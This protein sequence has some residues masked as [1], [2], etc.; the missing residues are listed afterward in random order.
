MPKT[1][2]TSFKNKTLKEVLPYILMI[3]GILG[4]LASFVITIEKLHL[5][6]NPNYQPTCSINPV[7]SCGPIMASPEASAF[8]FPNPLIGIFGFALVINVGV[9]MLAGAKLKGWYWKLFNLGT[10]F[11]IVF[12]HWLIYEALFDIGALCIY[13]NLAW[14]VTAPIFWY[15]TLYNLREGHLKTPKKLASVVAFASK[16][17]GDILL[18]WYIGLIGIVLNRF[19]YYWSTLL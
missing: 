17:H 18:V 13:C 5:L 10:L 11:G 4:F 6:Q 9:S 2:A 16:H 7:I 15:T 3:G 1:Q 12:V 14:V 8:G 19:W